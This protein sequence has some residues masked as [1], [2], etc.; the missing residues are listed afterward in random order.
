M[1]EHRGAIT[2]EGELYPSPRQG[3]DYLDLEPPAP[4][5]AVPLG[6]HLYWARI[7]L[8]MELNHINVWLLDDGE[9]GWTLVDTGMSEDVC[10]EAWGTLEQQLLRG[11]PLRRILVTHDHPDHM[12][13]AGWLAQRHGA[14]LWMSAIGHRSTL[15]F[16]ATPGEEVDARRLRFVGSHGMEVSPDGARRTGGGTEHGRWYGV[17]PPL[18]RPIAG[19]DRIEAGGRAWDVI[20]TS[21]HCRGHLCL[22]DAANRVLISGDQVL[23]TISP[24]VS[25]LATRP[26]SNPLAEFLDSLARLEV[27]LL[28]REIEVGPAAPGPKLARVVKEVE[29]EV[30][31][32]GRHRAAVQQHVLLLQVPAPGTHHQGRQ[33]LPQ[34]VPLAVGALVLQGP[35]HRVHA[36][37]LARDD[38]GPG[39]RERVLEVG[40]EHPRPGVERVDHH[41]PLHRAGDLDPA[42]G[43]VGGRRSHTPRALANL[44]GLREEGR[45]LAGPD[46]ALNLAPPREELLPARR[47]PADQQLDEPHGVGCE[48]A[49]QAGHVG[50]ANLE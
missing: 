15:E 16:L 27:A 19:G 50:P 39:R 43:E 25:V 18:A 13:L 22:H 46:A 45:Q 48:D 10:R 33:P 21:G 8:P 30:H 44:R 38:V 14:P 20:E 4:G 6:T 32:A 37:G 1:T 11:R 40:H 42:V 17:V 28:L 26:E 9:G 31:Q 29:T 2:S 35:P 49:I 7:P 5:Q 3:L 47:E 34:G 12:G 41:L 36:V 23:P 24:N